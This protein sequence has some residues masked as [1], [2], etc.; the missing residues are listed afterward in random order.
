[1]ALGLSVQQQAAAAGNA[2]PDAVTQL[3]PLGA[4]LQPGDVVT[5]VYAAGEA[6][7]PEQEPGTGA[8]Q[9]GS[10]EQGQTGVPLDA[11]VGS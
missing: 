4:A 6:A 9:V 11:A 8:T 5:V 7:A 10:T 3:S 1:A 2:A